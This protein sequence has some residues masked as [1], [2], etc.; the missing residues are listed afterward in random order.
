MRHLPAGA[1]R[2]RIRG[3]QGR[4]VQA[5]RALKKRIVADRKKAAKRAKKKA[6]M[7]KKER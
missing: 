3:L 6:A 1:L 2:S 5:K 4:L 7:Q